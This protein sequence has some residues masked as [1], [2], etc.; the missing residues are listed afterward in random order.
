MGGVFDRAEFFTVGQALTNA[1]KSEEQATGGGQIIV[2]ESAFKHVKNQFYDGIEI[3]SEE[4]K[5]FYR[6]TKVIIGVSGRADA[7]LMKSQ[8]KYDRMAQIQKSLRSCVPA[9]VIPYLEIGYEQ[10]GSETRPLTVM[11]ASL[12]VDLS[13]ASSVEGMNKIQKIVTTV[14]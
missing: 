11:F 8:V 6:V 4:N 9:A 13:S 5:K 12:G 14:Q 1:L 3:I 7:V 10:F 2:S